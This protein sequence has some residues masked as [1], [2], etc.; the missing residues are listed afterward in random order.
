MQESTDRFPPLNLP[1]ADI[2]ISTEGNHATVYCRLR[3]RM[4]ALTP[5]EW[6]RQNFVGMLIDNLGYP[7]GLMANEVS[8]KLNSLSRRADTVVYDRTGHPL[9]IVEYKAPSVAITQRVFE[10]IIRY[11]IVLRA[12]YLVVSNGLT[13]YCCRLKTTGPEFL[14]E[15]PR[16][17]E[18]SKEVGHTD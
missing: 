13:H 11:H 6:V 16:Y 18:L 14:R 5:E 15:I 12:R 17:S 10:Q 1:A 8:L 4:V 7:A 9:M 3:R 2:Q